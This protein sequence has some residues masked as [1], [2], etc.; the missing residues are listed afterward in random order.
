MFV[1]WNLVDG[2]TSVNEAELRWRSSAFP[3]LPHAEKLL[4]SCQ[5]FFFFVPAASKEAVETFELV[6]RSSACV[7]LSFYHVEAMCPLSVID[8]TSHAQP[9]PEGL[10]IQETQ[11]GGRQGA[12][13][14]DVEE[15]GR[16]TH[17][18]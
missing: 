18:A 6:P 12:H 10:Y 16:E 15:T 7:S 3:S 8:S 13:P 1:P 2:D 17:G 4:A 14:A 11:E 5:S 9:G